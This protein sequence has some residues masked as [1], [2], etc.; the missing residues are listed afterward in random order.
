MSTFIFTGQ[1]NTFSNSVQINPF[2]S[3]L[4]PALTIDQEKIS[5]WNYTVLSEAAATGPQIPTSGIVY[6]YPY[7]V[8][9][10]DDFANNP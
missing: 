9:L 1:A 3:E 8:P 4:T 5:F 7:A 10:F 6:P 2:Y